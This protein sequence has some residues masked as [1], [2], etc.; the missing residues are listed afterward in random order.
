[1]KTFTHIL[2]KHRFALAVVLAAF[3]QASCGGGN[4]K[5]K[6]ETT[7]QA[8]TPV[9]TQQQQVFSMCMLANISAYYNGNSDIQT[10]TTTAVNNV[11]ADTGV[12]RLIGTWKCV[13]GPFVYKSR[14]NTGRITD[15]AANTMFIARQENTSNFVVAIAGT[16]PASAF[17]W[18]FEDLNVIPMWWNDNDTTQGHV[19][20]ATKTGVAILETMGLDD[21]KVPAGDYLKGM[22]EVVQ[23]M[24]IW[25]TGHSLGGALAPS[26]AL[27]LKDTWPTQKVPG[28]NVLAAAGASPGDSVF[29]AYY[30]NR[31]GSNTTRVWNT[32]DVVP[33]GYEADMMA[34]VDTL[35]PRDSV[36]PLD[37]ITSYLMNKI[38]QKVQS[39]KFQ[40]RQLRPAGTYAFTSAIYT[41]DSATHTSANFSDTSYTG[42]ILFQHIPAY[43]VYFQTLDFQK[44]VQRVVGTPNPFFTQGGYLVPVWPSNADH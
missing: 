8:N 32:R 16:D 2:Q 41:K 6:E 9:F 37:K 33:H 27:H 35:Y 25:V 21:E 17:E 18:E 24:Q 12:Q 38:V 34:E 39:L 28:I 40:Y 22:S 23:N 29:A 15:T 1:M 20:A 44:A 4:E 42:Q 26:Y 13:W 7:P 30:N 5:T 31:L 10:P 3:M 11:L 14:T 36:Q 19:S 43:G